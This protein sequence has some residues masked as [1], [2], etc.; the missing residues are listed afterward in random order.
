M[1]YIYIHACNIYISIIFNA[2]TKTYSIQALS[3]LYQGSIKAL[4]R[5]Y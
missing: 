4:L 5:L 3:R 2:R 1:I